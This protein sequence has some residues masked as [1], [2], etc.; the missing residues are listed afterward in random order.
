MAIETPERSA[1]PD[2]EVTVEYRDP[3]LADQDADTSGSPVIA[4]D[5]WQSWFQ[6]W[7]AQLNLDLSP[8][9]A[10]EL[11]LLLTDDAE[12]QQLN[13]QFRHQDKPTDVLSFAALETEGAV[14]EMLRHEIPLNLG[15]IIISVDTAQRQADERGHSLRWELAW[16][17]THGLL[18][19]LGWDHPTEERLQEMLD[20]QDLL[21]D[22]IALT[23]T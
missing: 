23:A 10:Y 5:C 6:T 21:L 4:I 19:L 15:D 9:N 13:A 22:A 2:V 3:L 1:L 16:L 8:I 17:A 20:Q 11:S 18:H 12:I 7:L 14:P